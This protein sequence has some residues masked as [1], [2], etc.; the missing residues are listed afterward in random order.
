MIS[1]NGS[2]SLT[3]G[4]TLALNFQPGH[5][6]VGGETLQDVILT[7]NSSITGTLPTIEH[8]LGPAYTLS[9]SVD[10]DNNLDITISVA[11]ERTFTAASGNFALNTNWSGDVAPVSTDNVYIGN[12]PTASVTGTTTETINSLTVDSGRTLTW[13]AGTLT[14]NQGSNVFAGGVFWLNSTS[15]GTANLAVNDYLGIDGTFYWRNGGIT[16]DG[17]DTVSVNGHF[18]FDMGE[19]NT[20]GVDLQVNGTGTITGAGTTLTGTGNLG[21]NGMINVTSSPTIS[22][23]VTIGSGGDVTIGDTVTTTVNMTAGVTNDGSLTL[24]TLSSTGAT[25]LNLGTAALTNTQSGSLIF[26]DTGGLKPGLT[27]DLGDGAV[28]ANQGTIDVQADATLIVADATLDTRGGTINIYSGQT[29]TLDGGALGATIQIDGGTVFGDSGTMAFTGNT[30]FQVDTPTYVDTNIIFDSSSATTINITG[31]GDLHFGPNTVFSL[32][33]N[34]VVD[35]D[36]SDPQT[37]DLVNFGTLELYGEGITVQSTFENQGDLNITGGG[38]SPHVFEHSFTN[39]GTLVLEQDSPSINAIDINDGG[40][41]GTLD[42]QGEF[43]SL[44]TGSYG[45]AN[46]FKGQLVNQ[47]TVAVAY[48]LE[49]A[50]DTSS[51]T[52]DNFGTIDILGGQTLTLAANNS[53]TNHAGGT[54]EGEGTLDVSAGGVSFV[55][56]GML[57][58]GGTAAGTLTIFGGSNT[59]FGASSEIEIDLNGEGLSDQ[60]QINGAGPVTLGGK[61]RFN[62]SPTGQWDFLIAAAGLMGSFQTIEGTDLGGGQILDVTE[63]TTSS[64]VTLTVETRSASNLGTT[65]G[66]TLT[67][68]VSPDIVYADGGNDVIDITAGATDDIVFGGAGDDVIKT[69]TGFKRIVGGDGVDQIELIAS[70]DYR[71]LD[72]HQLEYVEVIDLDDGLNSAQTIELDAV[73]IANIVDGSDALDNDPTVDTLAVIG[74]S[75]DLVILY[76]DY[77]LVGNSSLDLRNPG[78]YEPFDQLYDDGAKSAVLVDEHVQ[79]EVQRTGGEVYRFGSSG[80]DTLSGDLNGATADKLYGRGGDDGL[81]YDAADLVIDGGSGVDTLLGASG[82]IDLSNVSNIEAIDTTDASPTALDLNSADLFNVVGDNALNELLNDGAKKI[83]INGDTTDTVTL[84][85]NTLWDINSGLTGGLS[86]TYTEETL[87]GGTYVKFTTSAGIDVY[88]HANLVDDTPM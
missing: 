65:A 61:L 22:V 2:L 40:G 11:Y 18:D 88:V 86:S 60:L 45:Q 39:W 49:L 51:V 54:I 37:T 16:G 13:E 20:L 55:N 17:N 57:L 83:I 66:E 52:H 87:F 79:V 72:G 70:F 8:N 42:N 23:P 25:S 81:Q 48:G 34:S 4:N 5:G 64:T 53:L 10:L 36:D 35:I 9:A 28:F 21:L 29:L 41:V 50:E 14:L 31:T 6:I 62:G 32:V 67:G 44:E 47:G 56:D 73:A 76:G 69:G 38:A 59:S 80:S 82:S 19:T 77:D 74:D 24:D 85:G 27:L 12:D 3:A 33:S 75:Q 58:P 1:T 26:K 84:D 15:T 68:T 30:T 7:T 63:S 71:T 46:V 43:I 78:T